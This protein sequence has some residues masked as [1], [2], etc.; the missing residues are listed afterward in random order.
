MKVNE[1]KEGVNMPTIVEQIELY[2]KELIQRS[3]LDTVEIRRADLA[4]L[5]TC[6]PSQINYVLGTRFTTDRGFIVETRRGGGGYV[7]ITR[8]T[9]EHKQLLKR[10]EGCSNE[11][12][13]ESFIIRLYEDGFLTKREAIFIKEMLRLRYGMNIEESQKELFSSHIL[14]AIAMLLRE[15]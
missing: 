5:F 7:R 2:L 6:A 4:N 10:M 8:L 11:D 3:A 14:K 15:G 1:D 9:T 13:L 12:A